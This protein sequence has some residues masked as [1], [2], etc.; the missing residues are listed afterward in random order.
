MKIK[1]CHIKNFTVFEDQE[2]EF[3]DGINVIIGANG[4]GKS[5][6]M[7]ILYAMMQWLTSENVQQHSK[8]E[9]DEM[10]S[11]NIFFSLLNGMFKPE[12]GN[13]SRLLRNKH[14]I[15]EIV[16][17]T[18]QYQKKIV[19]LKEEKDR[20]YN[21]NIRFYLDYDG[22]ELGRHTL[23]LDYRS[24]IECP[25]NAIGI[26]I[27]PNDSLSIYPGFT[28]S[29]EKR[30]LAF[31]QTYYDICKALSAAPLKKKHVMLSNLIP[32]LE[33][34][35]EGE[36]IQK[37]DRFYVQ[38]KNNER[39]LESNLLAEGHRKIA[40]LL[41]LILNG[42][43]DQDT[44]LFWDEPEANMNPRL[45]KHIANVLRKLADAGVQV[46]LATHDYLLTGELSIAAEYQTQPQVPVRFIGLSRMNDEPVTVQTG[47][48][49]AGLQNNPILEEFA[50]HY[51]R[52]RL[53]FYE[54]G[55]AV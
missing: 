27:P 22:T 15:A 28:A 26:I 41:C 9:L 12:D 20:V 5:H 2:I 51:D 46:F 7:K 44:I 39:M 1:N 13:P 10:N 43:L 45:I 3:C 29:Y 32:D 4:T 6:L 47:D 24:N 54:T 36:V 14:D 52:E 8:D 31:D 49:L 42:S 37:G 53:L 11:N 18:N 50:A 40:T 16:L 48:T 34:I 23:Y 19:I 35:L 25:P 30:E 21:P 17:H 38:S 33:S 55:A